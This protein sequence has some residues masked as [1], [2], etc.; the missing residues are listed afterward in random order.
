M[1]KKA[2]NP[3]PVVE[4]TDSGLIR[5]VSRRGEQV[6]LTSEDQALLLRTLLGVQD[7]FDRPLTPPF[8]VRVTVEYEMDSE[9]TTPCRNILIPTAN[10]KNA[11][12]VQAWL[13]ST[14]KKFAKPDIFEVDL[15]ALPEKDFHPDELKIIPGDPLK[16][17]GNKFFVE[18]LETY[19][20]I[21]AV[22]Q[23][24]W[25]TLTEDEWQA[26]LA[27][28]SKGSRT[29]TRDRIVEIAGAA[30]LVAKPRKKTKA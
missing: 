21:A 10:L 18:L 8:V 4:H 6:L 3:G 5:F 26:I 25:D 30:V 9:Q 12:L 22:G 28:T 11:G 14:I 7:R 29:W 19:E 27:I 1:A 16:V 17:Y 24:F 23:D 15:L 2:Y 20:H 13:R